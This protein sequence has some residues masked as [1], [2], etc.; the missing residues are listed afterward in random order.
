MTI[1][2]PANPKSRPRS[3]AVRPGGQ[4][5]FLVRLRYQVSGAVLIGVGLA[6]VAR[7][8]LNLDVQFGGGSMQNTFLGT[9]AAV[10]VGFF[11]MLA[12]VGWEPHERHKGTAP[13][14]GTVTSTVAAHQPAAALPH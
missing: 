7:G 12:L 4:G 3:A 2:F 11:V 10:L 9:L 1:A 6:S 14:S 8:A 5:G 13:V